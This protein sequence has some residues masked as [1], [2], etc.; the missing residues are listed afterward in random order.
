MLQKIKDL[1]QIRELIGDIK[2]AVDSQNSQIDLL[3][4]NIATLSIEL[5]NVKANFHDF[6]DKH[7]QF[8]NILS[9]TTSKITESKEEFMREINDFRLQKTQMQQRMMENA[10]SELK[11]SLERV[12]VDVARYNDL[13]KEVDAVSQKIAKASSE[14]EKFVKISSSINARD[15]ELDKFARQLVE[16]DREKL[17][18]M[19]KIDT[20]ER[21]CSKQRQMMR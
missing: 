21:L 18:L 3:R 17:E 2:K 9:S 12:K 13:K 5:N 4:S 8:F 6:N 7:S 16:L 11:E 10:D 15:F 1:M 19:R 14:I 20:L